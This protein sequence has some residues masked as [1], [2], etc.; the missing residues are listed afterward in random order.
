[1][2][3]QFEKLEELVIDQKYITLTHPIFKK[4]SKSTFPWLKYIE[5]PNISKDID[6]LVNVKSISGIL[7]FPLFDVD[8]Y[9][10]NKFGTRSLNIKSWDYDTFI[11]KVEEFG[12]DEFH[13]IY[14]LEHIAWTALIWCD[15]LK[16]CMFNR[17][18]FK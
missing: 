18:V 4:I 12:N 16:I 9:F 17:K 1:M 6:W 5:F 8:H 15:L 2:S 7:E 13:S 3:K 14:N 10:T 11:H